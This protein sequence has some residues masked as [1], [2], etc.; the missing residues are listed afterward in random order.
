MTVVRQFW[1]AK[2]KGENVAIR[3]ATAVMSVKSVLVPN[4]AEMFAIL[5]AVKT[6]RFVLIG[7]TAFAVMQVKRHTET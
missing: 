3:T 4:V 2:I 5:P 6:D 7:I 1:I